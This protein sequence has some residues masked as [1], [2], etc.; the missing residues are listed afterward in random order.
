[1]NKTKKNSIILNF[2]DKTLGPV[3][4]YSSDG[5]LCK[6]ENDRIGS[7]EKRKLELACEEENMVSENIVNKDDNFLFSGLQAV[8]PIYRGP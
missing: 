8:K 7:P 6:W 1:M 5:L 2:L 4:Y 3:E